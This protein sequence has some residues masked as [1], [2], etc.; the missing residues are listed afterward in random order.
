MTLT[1]MWASVN[2]TDK[3]LREETR[4]LRVAANSTQRE[5]E[6]VLS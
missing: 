5:I 1:D 4:S 2:K 6:K 3:E